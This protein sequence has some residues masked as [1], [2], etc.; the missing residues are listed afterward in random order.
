[1]LRTPI[2]HVLYKS[3]VLCAGHA[4]SKSYM[5]NSKAACRERETFPFVTKRNLFLSPVNRINA[6]QIDDGG[7]APWCLRDCQLI[8]GSAERVHCITEAR[9]WMTFLTVL[10]GSKYFSTNMDVHTDWA[11]AWRG[12]WPM[13][14]I[15]AIFPC[16]QSSVL[17]SPSTSLWNQPLQASMLSS[18]L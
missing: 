7:I 6:T 12:N 4:A 11:A 2:L 17:V 9:T 10:H 8:T 15:R 1:M 18:Q 5:P 16:L 3:V 14:P 13:F